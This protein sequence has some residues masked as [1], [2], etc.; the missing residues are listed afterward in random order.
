[1]IFS[2]TGWRAW[3]CV[4]TLSI[5]SATISAADGP[6]GR[7][8]DPRDL[9]RSGLVRHWTI[10]AEVVRSDRI[11][12]AFLH[13]SNTRAAAYFEV[14][15]G[16][17]LRE[18]LASLD[19]DAF[20]QALGLERAQELAE[21]R[22]EIIEQ[23]VAASLADKNLSPAEFMELVQGTS[24]ESIQRR[25]E[26]LEAAHQKVEVRKYVEPRMT[27]YTLN[28]QN[29]VQAFN[30]ETGEVRWS[31]QV[32]TR[33]GFG[34]GIAA[35]DA[36]V[37]VGVGNAIYC[38]EADQGRILWHHPCSGPPNGAPGMSH[39]HVF[40]PLMNG[41]LEAFPI[42]RD[43][44]GSEFY[45]S[46][47]RASAQPLVTGRTVSW[48]TDAGHYNVA[49][50]DRIGP[51][52]YRIRTNGPIVTSPAKLGR[53]LF[54]AST[55]GYVYAVD[56]ILGSIYWQF[57]TG[58]SIS[59]SPFAVEDGVYFVTDNKELFK[60]DYK[61]GLTPAAWPKSVHGIQRLVGAANEFV[62]AQDTT[63]NLLA[64]RADTG[65]LANSIYVGETFPLL[66]SA[67]DR[68]ILV[69][70]SG[71]IHCLRQLAQV[72][73]KFHVPVSESVTAGQAEQ[74]TRHAT[75]F[76]PAS[77]NP[78]ETADELEKDPFE[79]DEPVYANPFVVATEGEVNPFALEG[80]AQPGGESDKPATDSSVDKANDNPAEPPKDVDD[81]F[82]GG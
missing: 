3:C 22:R 74:P 4:A 14:F 35:N 69:S 47:G 26:L 64:I 31:R 67:T 18:R 16:D 70:R 81:P 33:A 24:P 38:L 37:A 51:I 49:Y 6:A 68:L 7:A 60:V 17:E 77:R 12:F 30:A 19:R 63:G 71:S 13:V 1:M 61:T 54:V 75:Q 36:M 25:Q 56:E 76:Q 65:A 27:L 57:S 41:R 10:Q 79:A 46:H 40:V 45:V 50:F 2:N 72:H 20:G 32:A 80:P 58:S 21:L 55:D 11:E 9:A 34:M 78:F 82:S 39:T 44:I 52:K 28:G 66:N 62:Y 43:G 29:V 73:P 8:L 48:P 23:Q 15:V 59:Q 42:A 53:T 5:F